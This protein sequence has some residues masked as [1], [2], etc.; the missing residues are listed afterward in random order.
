MLFSRRLRRLLRMPGPLP[1]PGRAP[2]PYRRGLQSQSATGAPPLR[3]RVR[4]G[5]VRHRCRAARV[6]RV[7]AM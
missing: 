2:L 6:G 4:R 1:R 3:L 7:P 5:R